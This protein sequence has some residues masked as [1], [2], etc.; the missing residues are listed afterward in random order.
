[1]NSFKLVFFAQLILCGPIICSCTSE[2][3]MSDARPSPLDAYTDSLV[4]HDAG[5]ILPGYEYLGD[6][7]VQDTGRTAEFAIP[8]KDGTT[9]FALAIFPISDSDE[10]FCI[11]LESLRSSMDTYWI[12]EPEEGGTWWP[13]CLEC[14]ERA[15]IGLNRGFYI[16]PNSGQE[17]DLSL[18]IRAV[19]GIR[20]CKTFRPSIAAV[21]T[22]PDAVRVYRKEWAVLPATSGTLDLHF[23]YGSGSRFFD[24]E[25]SNDSLLEEAIE[26]VREVLAQANLSIG[27][28][29]Y[30][31]VSLDSSHINFSSTDYGEIEKALLSASRNVPSPVFPCEQEPITI[32][33][34]SCLQN[35]VPEGGTRSPEGISPYLPGGIKFENLAD[36]IL[37]KDGSCGPVSSSLYWPSGS[38][39][40]RVIAHEL[41][42]YLGLYHSVEENGLS[43]HLEDTDQEN[44]MYYSPNRFNAILTPLQQE[45]IRH[46]PRICY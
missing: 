23:V 17:R 37:V 34:V 22:L 29:S 4:S 45:A 28:L 41:G 3:A 44:L 42:H 30:D 31:R 5:A 26:V 40:G 25:E 13:F 33:L 20:S 36:G 8:L 27:N 12:D 19:A 10:P 46:H 43:D 11:Q 2:G 9:S 14:I 35:E 32:L 21:D 24:Q 16:I 38:Q 15:T 7:S 1:M 18:P 39:F 6:F